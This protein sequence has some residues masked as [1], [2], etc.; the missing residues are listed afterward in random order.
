MSQDF[1]NQL[2]LNLLA[3][4]SVIK[5]ADLVKVLSIRVSKAG[6]LG[7]VQRVSDPSLTRIVSITYDG[8]YVCSCEGSYNNICSHIVA[9]LIQASIRAPQQTIDIVR[10]MCGEEYK[11]RN[12][13]IPTQ[14]LLN[15]N[16]L[17]G[18]IPMG[19]LFGVFGVPATNKSLLSLQLSYTMFGFGANALLVDTEGGSGAHSLPFW[20]DRFNK[21]YGLEVQIVEVKYD[22]ETLKWKLDPAEDKIAKDKP[23]F[24][25]VDLRMIHKILSFHGVQCHLEITE[26]TKIKDKKTGEV[27][28]E[29]GGGKISVRLKSFEDNIKRT[30]IGQLVEKFNIKYIIYDSITNPQELFVSGQLNFPGRDDAQGLW[31]QQ[32]QEIAQE[33]NSTIIGI[34]HASKSPTD[35]YD[36]HG[37]PV[38]GKAVGHNFKYLL[39]IERFQGAMGAKPM[40]TDIGNKGQYINRRKIVMLRHPTKAP[41]SERYD[42][43]LHDDGFHD[44]KF[45]ADDK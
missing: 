33:F 18:G 27:I 2:P 37:H 35:Q 43:E 3:S 45:E 36:V 30:P 38:G 15:F 42:I 29:E 40:G 7:V 1:P 20:V 5:R 41:F 31:F 39:S 44:A 4:Q 9:V 19:A 12:A 8:L 32:I 10:Y 24:F 16:S 22:W 28:G 23:L 25:I 34:F 17:V 26:P 13:Y 21:R 6:I 11:M 14:D